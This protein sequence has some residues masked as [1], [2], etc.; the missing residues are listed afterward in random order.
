MKTLAELRPEIEIGSDVCGTID[1]GD[2]LV[3]THY[4]FRS[5]VTGLF[6]RAYEYGDYNSYHAYGCTAVRVRLVS[7][8]E[9]GIRPR[10]LL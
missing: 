5:R 10:R 3:Q 4:V 6:V 9:R 8:D 2:G 7:E 1:L